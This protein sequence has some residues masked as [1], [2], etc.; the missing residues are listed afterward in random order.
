MGER[1]R[2]GNSS[3]QEA[4]TALHSNISAKLKYPLPACTLSE[5]ECKSI[6]YPA[7]QVA[8]PKSGIT[9]C[10]A[11]DV[12]DGPSRSVGAGVLSLFH[13]MG[14][15]RT[16]I[17]VEHAFRDTPLGKHIR[18]CIEDIVIDAGLYGLIWDMKFSDIE[19]Y[20]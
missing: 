16:S 20:I 11:T 9:L 12:R 8:L 5:K 18:V 13:Y 10:I 1:V 3:R 6:T 4:W 17:L 2:R 7:I 14:T 19:R 15:S